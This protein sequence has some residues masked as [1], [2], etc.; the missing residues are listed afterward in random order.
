MRTRTMGG[1]ISALALGLAGCSSGNGMSAMER[2]VGVLD[3]HLGEIRAETAAHDATVFSASNLDAVRNEETRHGDV[4]AGHE[5]MMNDTLAHMD[6]CHDG[7]GNSPDTGPMVGAMAQI[8]EE[9]LEHMAVMG[10]S[11]NMGAAIGEEA[12][13]QGAMDAMLDALETMQN[14][15]M[16]GAGE[17]DCAGGMM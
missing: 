11:G 1:W 4:L 15:M 12:D 13:H 3:R 10:S 2:D 8:G 5:G 14:G 16:S 6:S 7:M 9:R 17:Y